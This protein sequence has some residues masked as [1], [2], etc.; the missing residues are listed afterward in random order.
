[1][2]YKVKRYEDSD[3]IRVRDFLAESYSKG[4]TN[5]RI[6]RWNFAFSLASTMNDGLSQLKKSIGIF[7]NEKDEIISVVNSEGEMCA[8]VFFQLTNVNRSRKLLSDMFE[9]AESNSTLR[10]DEGEILRAFI[11]NTDKELINL[12][13]ERGYVKTSKIDNN[14]TIEGNVR[15]AKTMPDGFTFTTGDKLGTEKKALAHA[16]AF[17]YMNNEIYLKRAE[18][19]FRKLS[20][21]PDYRLDL[22]VFILDHDGE[23]ASFASMWYDRRNQIAMLEPMGTLPDYRRMG[24]G[25]LALHEG[26]R[27]CM[28]LGAE[29][30]YGGDQQFY[31]D[32]G[33][34]VEFTYEIWKKIL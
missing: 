24:L 16:K 15:T 6:E 31:Y 19:G 33:F 14:T 34:K 29:K 7:E 21:M 32:I 27:R 20:E 5:W 11:P 18:I 17:G 8:E 30:I 4:G 10:T 2:N 12:A 3:F 26:I 1:M 23:P 25:S 9:F 22:D 28:E 13:I